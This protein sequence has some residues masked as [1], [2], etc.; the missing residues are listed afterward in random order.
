MGNQLDV[1]IGHPEHDLLFIATQ[2]ARVAGLKVPSQS[3]S[4]TAVKA[5]T[6]AVM[7]GSIQFV[8]AIE[9]PKGLQPTTWLLSD[10]ATYQMLLRGHAPASEPFRKWLTEEVI[11]SIIKTGS[12]DI[13]TSKTPEAQQ[14]NMDF[15]DLRA[16]IGNMAI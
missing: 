7:V 15:G 8:E 13:G 9:R 6:K 12:Y 16:L 4:R 5:P 10:K 3:A 11:P 14:L 2:V 1:L